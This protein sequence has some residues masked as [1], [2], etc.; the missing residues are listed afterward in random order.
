MPLDNFWGKT[1]EQV[2]QDLKL[3]NNPAAGIPAGPVD[4]ELAVDGYFPNTIPAVDPALR[5]R[6]VHPGGRNRLF[7]DGHG[8][9][10]RDGRTP[11]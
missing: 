6:S 7:L 1:E 3:A 4:V 8:A 9:F 11:R 10:L 2:V 5:G